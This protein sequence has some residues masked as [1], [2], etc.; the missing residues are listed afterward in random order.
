MTVLKVKEKGH[1]LNIPGL[2]PVRSPVEINIRKCNIDLVITSLR[3]QGIKS[4]EII[5]TDDKSV[6]KVERKQSVKTV[7]EED[8][9]YKEEINKKFSNLENMI[10]ELIVNRTGNTDENK[11]QITDKLDTLEVL[12]RHLLNKQRDDMLEEKLLKD[13]PEIEELDKFIPEVNIK[14]MELKGNTTK[15]TIQQDEVDPDNLDLLSK[16]L[17][18]KK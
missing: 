15:T 8:K 17:D 10:S 4:Y 6:K 14:G 5:E 1:L 16:L 11:E 12:T 3:R 18:T 7:V 2:M 13:E 9:S